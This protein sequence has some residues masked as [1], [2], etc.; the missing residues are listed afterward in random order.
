[1]YFDPDSMVIH[2]FFAKQKG[3]G[4]NDVT[5][6]LAD[7]HSELMAEVERNREAIAELVEALT[8]ERDAWT[9]IAINAPVWLEKFAE[10][11]ID[12]INRVT[13]K[14]DTKKEST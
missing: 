5:Q 14:Y 6:Y 12:A 11:R 10:Q 8:D 1:M 7:P 2:D 3:S 9:D 4:M 13:D